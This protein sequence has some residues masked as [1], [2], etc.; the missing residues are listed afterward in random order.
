M[1]RWDSRVRGL[2]ERPV[3]EKCA[4]NANSLPSP[5]SRQGLEAAEHEIG[6]Q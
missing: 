1:L 6:A 2:E 4:V 3:N 5:Q